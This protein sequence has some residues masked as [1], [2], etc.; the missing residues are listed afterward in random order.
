MHADDSPYRQVEDTERQA[1]AWLVLLG[2]GKATAADGQRFQQWCAAHPDNRVAF[3]RARAQWQRIR[4][5]G[6]ALEVAPL[7]RTRAD[8]H[9]L[10][11]RRAFIGASVAA[12]ACLAVVAALRPPLGL[13]PPVS[14]IAADFHT[15]TGEHRRINAGAGVEVELDTRTSLSRRTGH[16]GTAVELLEG[17]ASIHTRSPQP[18]TLLAG[19]GRVIAEAGPAWLDARVLDNQVNVACLQGA[20]RIEHPQGRLQLQAGQQ[21]RYDDR[22]TGDVAEASAAD[23]NAWTQGM[24]VFRRAPL[25]EVV[26]EINRYRR[27]K[28]LVRGVAAGRIPVSGRFAIADP[29]ATLDQLGMTLG[30]ALRRYPGRLVTLG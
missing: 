24:L 15:T 29:D 28:V 25:S 3:A 2:S 22:S 17:R 23:I 7:V 26:A 9:R 1:H 18:F 12:P 19:A 10:W 5:A 20:V 11:T 30:L 21:I 8:Q 14:A 27:G 13:W 16:A 6:R 4:E